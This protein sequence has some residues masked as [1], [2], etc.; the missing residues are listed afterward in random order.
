MSSCPYGDYAPGIA[1]HCTTAKGDL[2]FEDGASIAEKAQ[3]AK[4]HS[5]RG[6][7]YYTLG[8]E[9]PGLFDGLRAAYP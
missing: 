9:P 5:L 6:V 1:P 2:W 3:T 7:S 8:G 4:T